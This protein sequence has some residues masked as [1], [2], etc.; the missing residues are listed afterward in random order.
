MC[1]PYPL[2]DSSTHLEVAQ[3]E[4]DTYLDAI[5]KAKEAAATARESNSIP[6]FAD[7]TFDFAQQVFLPYHSHQVGPLYYKVPMKVVQVFGV[8][9]DSQPLQVNYLFNE[10]E[11][12]GTNGSKAHNPNSVISMIH[13]YLEKHSKKETLIIV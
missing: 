7:I 13:H 9:D 6:A 4:R 2:H 10:K 5:K 1:G 3:K 12:I 11:N 8:C